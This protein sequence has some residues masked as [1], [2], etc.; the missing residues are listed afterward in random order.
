MRAVFLGA[1]CVPCIIF[2][3]APTSSALADPPATPPASSVRSN[4]LEEVVVTAER[5]KSTVQNTPISLTAITGAQLKARGLTSVEDIVREIPGLSVR[6][7]GPGQT[8]YEARGLSSTGGAAP[9]VGFYLNDVPMSP[10]A[11]AQTGK[12]VI[13]PDLYDI[14]TVEVLR[15]P[16]GTLYGSGSM[17]GTVRVVTNQ[18]KLGVYEGSI[19]GTASG[20][21]GGNGPNGA[22]NGMVNIPISD[23]LAIRLVASDLA[24]SGWI[25][26]V[27]L[28]PFPPDTL[29]RGNVLT[30]PVQSIK[31]G[32]NTEAMSTFRGSVLFTPTE[33]TTITGSVL[34]QNTRMG[35]YDEFDIPPGSPHLAHYEAAPVAEP[36]HDIVKIISLTGTQ[37][38]G[39]ATLTSDTAYWERNEKQTQDATENI[40]NTFGFDPYVALPYSEIDDTR[41]FS[42]EIRL[43]SPESE[44]RFRWVVG[45]FYSDLRSLWVE[46]SANPSP[47]ITNE[48][49][50]QNPSGLI[51]ESYNPYRIKQIAFFGDGSYNITDTIKFS[52]GARFNRYES[53]LEI[54]EWGLAA[55]EIS[56]PAQGANV[57]T[58]ADSVTPRFN[59]SWQPT[60]DFTGYIT[61]SQGYRPGGLNQSVPSYCGGAPSAYAAD[62][63]WNY[64][65]G[66][67]ARLFDGK[68]TI[69]SDFYY[70]RWTNIQ[71]LLLLTC[72]YEYYDNAGNGRT[73]GP[74]VEIT[75]KLTPEW[76]LSGSGAYTDAEITSPVPIL[77]AA[78]ASQAQPGTIST[79]PTATNCTIPILNVPKYT[80]SVSLA[81]STTLADKYQ[82]T[83][84]LTS[85]YV[86]PVVD[87]SYY[88]IINLPPYDLINARFS[89]GADRW[90]A[91]LFVNNLTNK[92]AQL[93]ANN[94]SFQFNTAAYYRVSTNQP[95][96]GGLE[97]SYRF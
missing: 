38:L 36:F 7:A 13:D 43:A 70:D 83:G 32:A 47:T 46:Y 23:K 19:D 96:T 39:F 80:A 71:Q 30:A 42:E 93:T 54:N 56:R 68:L 60:K 40:G 69:N 28:D 1:A 55:S 37:D 50:G 14:S 62:S 79:C 57:G 27:V 34:Y 9:T 76:T 18:P 26:R 66:E 75:A 65:I 78:V 97:L 15:G 5:H 94:T 82:F 91:T 24:R 67:K 88:P 3:A 21:E 48:T 51:F 16:Q 35:G 87:E 52:A 74:E 41:Q 33:D 8:E 22:L 12:V 49:P 17:G 81:Y 53:T 86:G 11:A 6:S 59:L 61:A 90:T 45:A 44:K 64:E 84:R 73:F 72:G 20:T 63:V 2:A 31:H 10:P 85:N 25:D 89:L 4:V 58:A 77:A 95:L 92:H 29:T